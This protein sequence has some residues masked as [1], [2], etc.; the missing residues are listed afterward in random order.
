MK[1]KTVTAILVIAVI[2]FILIFFIDDFILASSLLK[3]Q[4]TFGLAVGIIS[5][6]LCHFGNEPLRWWLILK[7]RHPDLTLSRIYHTV[8]ATALIS[9]GFPVHFGLPTRLILAK[10]V[11][12]MDYPSAGALLVIDSFFLYGAWILVGAAGVALLIPQWGLGTPV[13]IAGMMIAMAIGLAIFARYDWRHWQRFP[14]LS[15]TIKR[16]SSGLQMLSRK[17]AIGNT[18]LLGTDILIYGIRHTLILYALGVDCS[19]LQVILVV[20]MSIL[21]GFVSLM[22]LGLGGYDFSMIF[23]LTMIGVPREAA[24]AVPVINRITMVSTAA[25]LGVVSAGR[26][27]LNWR[28]IRDMKMEEG[29]TILKDRI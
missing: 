18:L 23:L 25:I 3:Q 1:I 22:P 24:L 27:G 16:F 17:A 26:L 21:A 28:K 4:M 6:T 7:A 19:L 29:K 11:L 12:G 15:G 14:L 2:F 20:A 13:G 10:K 9:Y 8:T 5:L